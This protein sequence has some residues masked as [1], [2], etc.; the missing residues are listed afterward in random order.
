MRRH[1]VARRL[2]T[3]LAVALLGG[4]PVVGCR[5]GK[6]AEAPTPA[7]PTTVRVENQGFP[8]MVIYVVQQNGQRYRLGQ[9]TGSTTQVLRIPS[10]FL[11][12]ATQLRFIA[13][14]IG[15]TRS[16]ISESV[17]VLPGDQVVLTIPPS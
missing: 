3:A 10:N 16:P 6:S 7:E 13:D 1:V 11:F 17:T 2:A 4:A 5:P 15:G 9:V 14:P 8:D 12:G